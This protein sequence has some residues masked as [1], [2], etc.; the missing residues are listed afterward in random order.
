LSI[1]LSRSRNIGAAW[2]AAALNLGWVMGMA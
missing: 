1:D 2:T